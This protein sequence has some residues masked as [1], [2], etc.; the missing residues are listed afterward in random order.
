MPGLMRTPGPARNGFLLAM[1]VGEA[2]F[3]KRA[4][5]GM[6][7]GRAPA[8]KMTSS[9][10]ASST[11]ATARISWT[12]AT[13]R[14]LFVLNLEQSKT[15]A[16]HRVAP[17]STGHDP[18]HVHKSKSTVHVVSFPTIGDHMP[19]VRD[20]A[21]YK[22]QRQRIL[23][24]AARIFGSNGY[25]KTTMDDVAEALEITK[26]ALYYYFQNKEDLL[27]DICEN[28]MDVAIETIDEII[29]DRALDETERMH[30]VVLAHLQLLEQRVDAFTVF[31]RELGL[32]DHPRAA[33]VR[34][35][36]RQFTER[37]EE[38]FSDAFASGAMRPMDARLAT[39]AVL[40][41]CNWSYRWMRS[42]HRSAEEIADVF[43]GI[44]QHGF[45]PEVSQQ[46]AEPRTLDP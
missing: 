4:G 23:D 45:A 46:V 7:V 30:R 34:V 10:T 21:R 42:E 36:Q 37:I 28:T 15:Y 41:M 16:E 39:L 40:G 38:M 6:T 18:L 26:A 19:R 1:H 11:R 44:L 5:T 32:R 14:P 2:P 31:F 29:D 17:N 33:A 8:S 22:A 25:E 43:S 9:T 12:H 35:K 20:E 13:P 24:E 27:Y 3:R